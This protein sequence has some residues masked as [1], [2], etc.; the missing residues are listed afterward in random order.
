MN[1]FLEIKEQ[2]PE[3]EPEKQLAVIQIMVNFLVCW[4]YIREHSFQD[5][6][7]I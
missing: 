2:I 5:L 4:V 6:L 1:L 3:W 7:L